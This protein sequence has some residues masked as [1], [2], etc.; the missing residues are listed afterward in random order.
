MFKIYELA[1]HKVHIEV[2]GH[3]C[4]LKTGLGRKLSEKGKNRMA[5]SKVLSVLGALIPQKWA[6]DHNL[7]CLVTKS[8]CQVLRFPAQH[9]DD[10]LIFSRQLPS[11]PDESG[12]AVGDQWGSASH[13]PSGQPGSCRRRNLPADHCQPVQTAVRNSTG[14]STIPQVAAGQESDNLGLC[15]VLE[16]DMT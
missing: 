13:Q 15:L 5:Y 1:L 2:G 16:A 8:T 6:L 11:V 3:S 9:F 7:W 12:S 10:Q 14:S 4:W